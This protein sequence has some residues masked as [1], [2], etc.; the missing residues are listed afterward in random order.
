MHV[1]IFIVILY[2]YYQDIKVN[3]LDTLEDGVN[4]KAVL[5]KQCLF[6][7]GLSVAPDTACLS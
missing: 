7:G 1:S 2:S 3:T 4:R 6:R 5:S